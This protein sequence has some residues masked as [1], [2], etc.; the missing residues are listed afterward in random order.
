MFRTSKKESILSIQNIQ[1][2]CKEVN[3]IHKK[4]GTI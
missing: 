4:V 1:L 3:K 2:C